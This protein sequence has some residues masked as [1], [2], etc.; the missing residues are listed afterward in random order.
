MKENTLLNI[1]IYLVVKFAF[2]E[3]VYRFLK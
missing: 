3:N 1:D 2:S